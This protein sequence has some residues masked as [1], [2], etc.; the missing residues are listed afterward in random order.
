MQNSNPAALLIMLSHFIIVHPHICFLPWFHL[1]PVQLYN[2]PYYIYIYF[3]NSLL[4]LWDL[5]ILIL[6]T[7]LWGLWLLLFVSYMTASVS[8]VSIIQSDSEYISAKLYI[9]LLI[10]V[11]LPVCKLLFLAV[12]IKLHTLNVCN[13]VK[14]C[15]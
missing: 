11:S 3:F 10:C 13:R 2:V 5:Q 7:P 6:G 15:Y 12:S 8:N 9:L 1:Y 4:W 14:V